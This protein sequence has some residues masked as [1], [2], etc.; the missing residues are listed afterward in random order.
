M[1]TGYF[2][3][4]LKNEGIL[5]KW[6]TD[7]FI[8]VYCNQYTIV[9]DENIQKSGVDFILTSKKIF[10]Y[11]L[12]YKVDFKAALTYVKPIM[13]KD[14]SKPPKMPTFAF[15]LSFLNQFKQEREGW[16]FGDNYNNTEYYMIAWIWANLPYDSINGYE[17]TKMEEFSYESI[18]EVEIMII[19]KDILQ[20]YA[21]QLNIDKDSTI[22]YSKAMRDKNLRE[23]PLV[24]NKKIPKLHYTSFLSEK[25]VNLVI[26]SEDL[27]KMAIFHQTITK[28]PQ[29]E[30]EIFENLQLLG[31]SVKET[32]TLFNNGYTIKEIITKRELV[33]SIII[34]HLSK[35]AKQGALK[36]TRFKLSEDKKISMNHVINKNKD[37]KLSSIK[38]ELDIMLGADTMSYDEIKLY[39]IEL[40]SNKKIRS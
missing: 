38:N 24:R 15:E 20:E 13:T 5:T 29:I 8:S 19:K 21:R 30:R 17:K 12:P 7:N 33:Q 11:D 18:K 28:L 23:F 10:N 6:I 26:H 31:P 22:T 36:P 40:Y 27:E 39:L 35:G 1:S 4:D 32:C 14:G 9:E 3:R 34:T 16:L 2:N 37:K 25:P